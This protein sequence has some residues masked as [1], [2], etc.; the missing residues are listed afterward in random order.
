M[1][2]FINH[3]IHQVHEDPVLCVYLPFFIIYHYSFL[4]FFLVFPPFNF[5][6]Y[7]QKWILE[8]SGKET[9]LKG[10]LWLRHCSR[11]LVELERVG[12]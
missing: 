11:M 7:F 5:W 3:T 4:L 6:S 2:C 1:S 10:S 9:F 8:L 12:V